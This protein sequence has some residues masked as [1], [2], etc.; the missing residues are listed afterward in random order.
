VLWAGMRCP[1]GTRGGGEW[2]EVEAG[3]GVGG[4]FRPGADLAG[5]PALLGGDQEGALAIHWMETFA[6]KSQ[7]GWPCHFACSPCHDE[8]LAVKSQPGWPRHF[9]CWAC[10][11]ETLALRSQPGWLWHFA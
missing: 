1:V 10:H 8:T 6:L 11:D 9:A 7:P 3:L 4:R 5:R 2:C